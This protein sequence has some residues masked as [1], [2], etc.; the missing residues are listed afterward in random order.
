MAPTSGRPRGSPLPDYGE[1]RLGRTIV[2][3]GL[4]LALG[5]AEHLLP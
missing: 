3:A 1:A 2:G 4:V 5:G